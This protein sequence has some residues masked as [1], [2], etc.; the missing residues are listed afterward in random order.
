M[1]GAVFAFATS[2]W[3]G[4]A[5][6]HPPRAWRRWLV[7]GIAA[8]YV[9]LAVAVILAIQHWH[10]GTAFDAATG[11]RF[12]IVV[13]IEF[14]ACGAGA[15]FLAVR[16][17]AEFIPVW[18]ALVVAVHFFPLAAIIG[19]P[20]MHVVGAMTTIAALAA[21]PIARKRSL[22]VSAVTGA[23]M[24]AALLIGAAVALTTALTW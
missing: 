21:V 20:W 18:I 13:G 11:K 6:E 12:G 8:A 7:A 22:P 3:F 5:L 10:D 24:G 19:Y 4:W 16:K 1:T 2:V 14:L 17:R 23:G 9:L 15:A